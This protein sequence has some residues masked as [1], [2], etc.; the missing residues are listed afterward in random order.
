[1]SLAREW[2]VAKG[3]LSDDLQ[4]FKRFMHRMWFSLYPRAKRTMG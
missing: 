2:M 4:V 1:M 3:L